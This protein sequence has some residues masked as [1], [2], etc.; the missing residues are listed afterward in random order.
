MGRG[1]TRIVVAGLGGGRVDHLL[2]N[3]LLLA[4]PRF[5]GV[6]VEAWIPGARLT[7]AHTEARLHGRV[8]DLCSLLPVGGAAEGVRTEGLQYPLLDETL[9]PG[10][11]RGVSN[12]FVSDEATVRLARGC[13]LAIQ[14]DGGP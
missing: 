7:V 4:S 11:T 2:A 9:T 5:A 12:V 3:V 8:G 6:R 10:S 1:A 13:V 14:P